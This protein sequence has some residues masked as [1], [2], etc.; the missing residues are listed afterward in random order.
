MISILDVLRHYSPVVTQTGQSN[1]SVI[2]P[3][4]KDGTERHPSCSVNV[5]KHLFHCFTCGESGTLKKLLLKLRVDPNLIPH[6]ES[7][8]L[9]VDKPEKWVLPE[10]VLSAYSYIPQP[11][12][13]AGF[14]PQVLADNEIGYDV[15][16]NCVIIPIRN[17]DGSLMALSSRNFTKNN[18]YSI[19]K[20]ELGDFMPFGYSPKIHSVLWRGH[21]ISNSPKLVI[22]E[23]FKAALWCVQAGYTATVALMGCAISKEQALLAADKTQNV[24]LMLDNNDAGI[25]GS[26]KVM[27]LLRDSGCTV[28]M[29]VYPDDRQQP[30][31][32]T[33]SELE[34]SIEGAIPH[35]Q[36]RR[37]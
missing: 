6:L 19:Y 21:K 31:Q 33:F 7:P 28:K 5:S 35:Y 20:D 36:W 10:H 24:V 1:F 15:R 18:R 11:W 4:H 9:R 34:S 29:A 25:S 22:V 16:N 13:D 23:G 32:L 12:V 26:D 17:N 3:Y 2:C 14:A 8:R 30:D 27:R 37:Q